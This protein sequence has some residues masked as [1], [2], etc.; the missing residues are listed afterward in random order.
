VAQDEGSWRRMR[1]RTWWGLQ[2]WVVKRPRWRR[3]GLGEGGGWGC[4]PGG[5]FGAFDQLRV[6]RGWGLCLAN[7]RRF[8]EG[9]WDPAGVVGD[10]GGRDPRPRGFSERNDLD[11]ALG[12]ID[13]VGDLK[14]QNRERIKEFEIKCWGLDFTGASGEFWLPMRMK[15]SRDIDI[16]VHERHCSP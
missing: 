16:A 6:G 2:R 4:C 14:N 1:V 13:W 10:F 12:P 7:G 9:E 3:G 15:I 8:G 11:L 5:V